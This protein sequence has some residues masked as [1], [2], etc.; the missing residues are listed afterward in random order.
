[1]SAYLTGDVPSYGLG[2]AVKAAAISLA[3]SLGSMA[4]NV[5]PDNAQSDKSSDTP[6]DD[7]ELNY[8][9]RH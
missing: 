9:P 3:A 1:L 8:S 6:S 5:M 4:D 7:N 2:V